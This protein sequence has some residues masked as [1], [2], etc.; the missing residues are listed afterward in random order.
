MRI[1]SVTL[2]CSWLLKAS[3]GPVLRVHWLLIGLLDPAV[4]LR[5]P[6]DDSDFSG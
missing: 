1:S 4:S 5:L 6:H 2:E 3:V